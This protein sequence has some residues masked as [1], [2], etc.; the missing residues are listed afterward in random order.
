MNKRFA[1]VVS[2]TLFIIGVMAIAISITQNNGYAYHAFA[3]CGVLSVLAD[4]I[5]IKTG[6]KMVNATL[7]QKRFVLIFQALVWAIGLAL[8]YYFELF[9]PH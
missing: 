4:F 8:V 3:L 2:L 6:N 5:S 9:H 1:N 7:G